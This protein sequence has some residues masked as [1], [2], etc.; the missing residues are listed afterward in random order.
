MRTS[1]LVLRQNSRISTNTSGNAS[2]GDITLTTPYLIA[3]DNSDIT[4]NARNSFGGRISIASDVVIGTGFRPQITPESDITASSELGAASSGTV[5]FTAPVTEL[6]PDFVTLP[7]EVLDP[8]QQVASTCDA[9]QGSRFV[10]TGRGGIPAN[11]TQAVGSDRPW[12][13]LR[14]LPVESSANEST[15]ES[16]TSGGDNELAR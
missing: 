9:A 14:Q 16:A 7:T 1:G 2:G 6:S 11:P 12:T 8:N 10:A 5:Q 4:A 13:D 3:Q 15:A